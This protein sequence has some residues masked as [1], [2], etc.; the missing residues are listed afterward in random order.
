[1][2]TNLS[3]D[4]FYMNK[5]I[6][7]TGHTGFKG[8]WLA[9]WLQKMGAEVIGY[10]LP[11]K[12][13]PNLYTAA[14]I[15]EGITS[16]Y[17]DIRDKNKVRE[18]I[19]EHK[20]SIIFHLAAQALVRESYAEPVETFETNVMGTVNLLDAARSEDSVSVC[21]IVTS[22]KCYE[23]KEIE[24]GY[25]EDDAMGGSDPYSASKGCAELVTSSYRTSFFKD[26][27]ERAILSVRAGNI[28]GGGDWAEDRLI[29][30]CVR[31][32]V[33]NDTVRLRYPDAVRPWQFVL[34][35]LYGY[36]LLAAKACFNPKTFSGPWNFGPDL[37]NND[38]VES[39]VKMI[40]DSWGDGSYESV[41]SEDQ[42]KESSILRLDC[43]KASENLFWKPAYSLREGISETINW[44][45]NFYF[46]S[47]VDT[48]D[49][50]IDQIEKYEAIIV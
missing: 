33:E 34:E 3:L 2:V 26:G 31:A 42:L 41:G 22:D 23:N 38:N 45:K 7:I 20:P 10:A 14:N 32:F 40:I 35:P 49:L 25:T 30:D 11:P 24:R 4:D 17:G 15:E 19:S 1:M 50:C 44:Y 21:L 36:L 18:V 48:K 6:L 43:S 39:L 37:N 5:R 27:K 8:S 9:L 29:P 16:I 28:F 12:A 47:K 46:N 13:D